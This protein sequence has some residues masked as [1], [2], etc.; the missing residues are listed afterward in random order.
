MIAILGDF[1]RDS[2]NMNDKDDLN[3]AE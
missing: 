2:H 1:P 3:S